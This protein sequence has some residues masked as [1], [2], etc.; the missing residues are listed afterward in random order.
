MLV[1]PRNAPCANCRHFKGVKQLGESEG[2][3]VF[4]CDAFP[5]GIPDDI[6]LGRN[7]H[8]KPYPGDHGIRFEA[9]GSTDLPASP[10]P[11]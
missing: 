9:K 6:L 10:I 2:T 8:R 3:Q 4:A 7:D 11:A 1:F 5:E